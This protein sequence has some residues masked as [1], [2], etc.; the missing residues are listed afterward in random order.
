[1]P[2]IAQDQ[3]RLLGAYVAARVKRLASLLGSVTVNKDGLTFGQAAQSPNG[4]AGTRVA[5]HTEHLLHVKV[6]STKGRHGPALNEVTT[7]KTQRAALSTP[8]VLGG[9]VTTT[10][11]SILDLVC[12]G[13]NGGE[14]LQLPAGRSPCVAALPRLPPPP[15]PPSPNCPFLLLHKP[16]L[17]KWRLAGSW[18][19]RLYHLHSVQELRK[20]ETSEDTISR[21]R[22]QLREAEEERRKAAQYGL[23]L[24]ENESL[25]QNRLDELQ[26][27]IVIITENFE[28]EKYTLQREVE[29]K[30]RMLGSLN[31]E[32]ETLKQQQNIQID[33]LRGQL[34]RLHAQEI[35]ELKNKVEKLKAT[36][37]ETLLSEK[38]LK[39]QVDHLKEVIASKSEELRAIS[40]RV[41]ETM[42]SEVLSLQLELQALEQAKRDLEDKV[43]DLQYSKEQ[44]ELGNSNLTNRVARL[45]EE[46]EEREKDLVSYC[47]ALEVWI[48]DT[49][50]DGENWECRS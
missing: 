22:S 49:L 8:G 46:K 47:N 31:H 1:M 32:Y 10:A 3:L 19:F 6:P 40:E 23:K 5:S 12:N 17:L 26:N 50:Y 29:L 18:S 36:L 43:R 14:D 20:M 24:V 11:G 2:T 44:L 21:L 15:P 13:V 7:K 42:S 30:N 25:L 48:S 45:E 41:H 9:P 34:E 39:H 27:E 38:Q 16:T 4:P 35:N 37:D 33:T 28:Q